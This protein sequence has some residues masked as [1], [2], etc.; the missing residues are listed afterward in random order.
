MEAVKLALLRKEFHQTVAPGVIS[1]GRL[2]LIVALYPR[3]V[4][5]NSEVF[6][7]QKL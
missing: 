7:S 5:L 6:L 4:L 1:N 2:S 3:S